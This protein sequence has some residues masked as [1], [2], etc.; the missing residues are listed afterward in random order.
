MEMICERCIMKRWIWIFAFL[1]CVVLAAPKNII[2]LIPDGT[3]H[4]S[5]TVARQLKGAPL[6]M[7]SF[8]NGA[9]QTRSLTHSVTDSAAAGTAM[10][11]GQR[12]YNSAVGVNAEKVPLRSISEWAKA[13]GKAVGI[14]TTDS[15]TG[16]TPAS[17]SAHVT[18]R[19]SDEIILE[20]QITSGFDLFLGGGRKYLTDD[21]AAL[22]RQEGF[23]FVTDRASLATAQGKT[24]GLFAS[25]LLLPELERRALPTEE[26]T[27]VEMTQKALDLLDDDPD[28][29]FLMIEG[30]QIDKGNHEHDL[31]WA[32]YELLAFDQ[33]VE[34]VMAWAQAHP[35]TVVF[36]A[37]DHETGGLTL[38]DESANGARAAALKAATPKRGSQVKP[39]TFFVKYASTWHTGADVFYG[40]NN[41]SIRLQRNDQIPMTLVG[42]EVATLPEITGRIEQR[43]GAIVLVAPDGKVYRAQRDAIYIPDTGKWYL[44]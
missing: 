36:F 32:T 44:R 24:F 34:M 38:H 35:D 27:L 13:Q 5:L 17:F 37:P 6:A 23:A 31:P 7:D 43:E 15:I 4:A 11:T 28:G 22:M 39:G 20:Q 26:P 12:T 21:L 19:H 2:L 40:A 10:A 25:N 1:P 29:F 3:G 30:A 16:A 42:M 18:Y 9:I 14:V 33:A 8:I 41:P